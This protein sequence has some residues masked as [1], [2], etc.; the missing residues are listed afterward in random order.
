M[1]IFGKKKIKEL[2]ELLNGAN[3]VIDD[4]N[5]SIREMAG[6]IKS[7]K[8]DIDKLCEELRIKREQIALLESKI[9]V[10]YRDEKGRF[11][12]KPEK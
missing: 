3:L 2:K 12:S 5:E 9:P 1:C 7:M 4:Q 8:N 6:H 11:I 10:Y